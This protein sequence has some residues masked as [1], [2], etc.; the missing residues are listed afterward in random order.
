MT[1]PRQLDARVFPELFSLEAA[2]GD[3]A[4]ESGPARAQEQQAAHQ[5]PAGQDTPSPPHPRASQMCEGF[6]SQNISPDSSRR[7]AEHS[8]SNTKQIRD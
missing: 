7:R 4:G 2:H 5:G 6:Q 1:R 3:E 8:L